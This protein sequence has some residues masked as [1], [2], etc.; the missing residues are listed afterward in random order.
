M[1]LYYDHRRRQVY[2]EDVGDHSQ[3]ISIQEA[4]TAFERAI[5]SDSNRAF[6][7]LIEANFDMEAVRL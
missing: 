7:K 5:I 6:R 1:I 3:P 2:R 4:K